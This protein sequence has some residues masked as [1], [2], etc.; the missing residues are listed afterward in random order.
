MFTVEDAKRVQRDFNLGDFHVVYSGPVNG[1]GFV[2]AHTDEE[3]G[4]GVNLWN[5]MIHRWLAESVPGF[6]ECCFPQAGW[7]RVES[8]HE[9]KVLVF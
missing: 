4:S 6:I 3:R 2:M 8:L 9:V 5:C 1:W 7:Y